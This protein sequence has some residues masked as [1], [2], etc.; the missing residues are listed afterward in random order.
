MMRPQT[1]RY[2][3]FAAAWSLCAAIGCSSADFREDEDGESSEARASVVP[4]GTS[5]VF[6][7]D[8]QVSTDTHDRGDMFSAT[9]RYGVSD[10]E[11]GEL[12]PPGVP[13]RWVVS[14]SST[15][16][17]EALLAVQLTSIQ[18]NGEWTPVV[19]DVTQAEVQADHPD[20]NTETGAKIA[21]G[22]AAGAIMGQILGS[23]T[24][25]TLTGAGVGAAVGTAVA[26]STRGGKAVLPQGSVITVRLAEP[27]VV[28]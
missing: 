3:S 25:S 15:E 11:G 5:L 2:A 8:E 23:G 1:L 21:V 17:G 20:T 16:D 19:G 22:T 13:S 18:V 6:S 28:S 7:V 14:E 9:L 26:L 4:T 27:L 24:R 10:G 12:V